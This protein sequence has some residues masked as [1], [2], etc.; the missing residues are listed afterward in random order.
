MACGNYLV[1]N[2]TELCGSNSGGLTAILF[3]SDTDKA[4]VTLNKEAGKFAPV[5]FSLARLTNSVSFDSFNKYASGLTSTGNYADATNTNYVTNELTITFNGVHELANF[6][7]LR[8]S[9][10]CSVVRTSL[11]DWYI[12]GYTNTARVTGSTVQTGQQATD[13]NNMQVTIAEDSLYSPIVADDNTAE[14]LDTF[15]GI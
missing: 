13:A 12:I 4:A 8:I 15:I 11:G 2:F 14:V 6:D 1:Q 9:Y 7:N 10:P 5:S 3:L